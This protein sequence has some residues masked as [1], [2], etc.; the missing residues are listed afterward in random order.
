MS[1]PSAGHR[2]LSRLTLSRRVGRA[3]IFGLVVVST[4]LL[5][6]WSMAVSG[7]KT[8]GP[9]GDYATI[10]AAIADLQ[11]NGVDGPLILELQ[12]NC[13]STGETFPITFPS[14]SGM[15]ATNTVTLRP[16]SNATNLSITSNNATATINLNGINYLIIDGRA[17]GAGTAKQ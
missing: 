11:T 3:W 2:P 13:T 16:A 1:H 10:T 7:T 5:A 14:L 15:S 9:G 17:G 12:S 8:I 4:A 6:A